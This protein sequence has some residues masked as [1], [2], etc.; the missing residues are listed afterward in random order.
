MSETLQYTTELSLEEEQD[1]LAIIEAAISGRAINFSTD[2]P[3]NFGDPRVALER[4]D[5][6]ANID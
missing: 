2:K 5:T 1:R 6:P 3:A 4:A